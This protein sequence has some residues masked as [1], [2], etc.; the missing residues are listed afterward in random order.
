MIITIARQCGCGAI[1][2]GRGL[3]RHYGIPLYTRSDLRAMTLTGENDEDSD[4]MEDFFEERPAD[5]LVYA[6]SSLETFSSPLPESKPVATLQK[7]IGD[8]DCIIIG[9][10]GNY[11]FRHRRDLVS[12]FLKGS[13]QARI[14]AAAREM[15]I[16]TDEAAEYVGNLDDSRIRYHHF[17]TRLTWGNANDYD[18]C[19]DS[20]RLGTEK[21]VSLIAEYADSI[22]ANTQRQ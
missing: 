6:I 21:T 1:N 22:T 13:L 15:H 4:N 17:Y 11:I 20:L 3:A 19:I 10:C 7:V 9:R 2:V 18:L 5:E 14:E 16:G 12:V 8:K